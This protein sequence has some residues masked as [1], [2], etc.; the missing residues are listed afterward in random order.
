MFAAEGPPISG[1]GRAWWGG[2]GMAHSYG[3]GLGPPLRSISNSTSRREALRL[4]ACSSLG[5]AESIVEATVS[6]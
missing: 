2:G 1:L 5:L 3:V 6:P 4:E